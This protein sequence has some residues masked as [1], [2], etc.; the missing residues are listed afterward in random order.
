MA[1]KA[2][3]SGLSKYG[4]VRKAGAIDNPILR[5]FIKKHKLDDQDSL[6]LGVILDLTDQMK[7][8]IKTTYRSLAETTELTTM[9]VYRS[10]GSLHRNRI[11]EYKPTG[12]YVHISFREID[13]SIEEISLAHVNAR[14]IKK[15]E[16]YLS[17]VKAQKYVPSGDLFDL[18]YPLVGRVVAAKIAEAFNA[19]VN[20]IN[21]RLESSF[22]LAMWKCRLKSFKTGIPLAEI[23][24]RESLPYYIDEIFLI[25]K[26]SSLLLCHVSRKDEKSIDKDLVGGMLS[27]INDFLKTS[28]R[29]GGSGA[30]GIQ[31]GEYRIMIFE[32]VYF[33]AALVVYGSPAM[34]FMRA[35][36]DVMGDIHATYRS[37]LKNFTGSMAGLEGIE[38]PL[39]ELM[40]ATNHAGYAGK[41]KSL[42]KVKILGIALAV[43]CVAAFAWWGFSAIRGWRLEKRIAG[44]IERVMPAFSS[45]VTVDVDGGTATVRGTVSSIQAGEEITKQIRSF[46]EIGKVRNRAVVTDYRSVETYKKDLDALRTGL[47]AFQ[48]VVVKQELEKIVVQFPAGVTEMANPQ[49]LQVKRV[50][51]ILKKYPLVH[52]DIVA[53]NDPQGGYEVN[54]A[55][56]EKR[57]AAVRDTLAGMGIDR[58]RLHIFDFDPDILT[59]DSRFEEFRDRRG[60][61][62]FA[63]YPD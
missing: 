50:Y 52:V 18:I 59:S 11:I 33:Y 37:Q 48:L 5:H 39:R 34:E 51:E 54:R 49:V 56:A 31:F 42:K 3:K 4:L 2:P 36:D 38:R 53:F 29:G 45:D 44:H 12:E 8:P 25:T 63:R 27:A 43:L 60:I 41:E 57:M 58:A 7:T 16:E 13:E 61:M 21:D 32:S 10:I 35:V 6:L 55:L 30:S 46:K 17:F 15:I 14:R 40:A 19:M 26:K 24:L 23:I 28:F 22:S 9:Q 47:D 20:Y 62:L 1:S